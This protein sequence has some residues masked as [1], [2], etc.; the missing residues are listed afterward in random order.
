M[1]APHPFRTSVLP[2]PALGGVSMVVSTVDLRGGI[3]VDRVRADSG[4]S[5]SRA[6]TD[7]AAPIR[8]GVSQPDG[9][10]TGAA[11]RSDRAHAVLR[12]YLRRSMPEELNLNI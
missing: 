9:T 10:A 5:P 12:P 11:P 3:N 4:H 6:S 2:S 8:S 7:K 1:Y